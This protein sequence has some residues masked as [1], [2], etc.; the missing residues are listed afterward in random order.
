MKKILIELT[1]D[2]AEE[3]VDLFRRVVE[4]LDRLDSMAEDLEELKEIVE[5]LLDDEDAQGTGE[6]M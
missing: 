6:K 2:D 4:V 3:C 5:D 1:D